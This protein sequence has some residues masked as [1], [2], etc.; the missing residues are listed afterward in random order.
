[1]DTLRAG[2]IQICTSEY[3]EAKE[4]E[5]KAKYLQRYPNIHSLCLIRSVFLHPFPHDTL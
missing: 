4:K 3:L 5:I 2:R 1:M